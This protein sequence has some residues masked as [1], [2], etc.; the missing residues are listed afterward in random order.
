MLILAL[1]T[2]CDETAVAVIRDGKEILSNLVASQI[3][4][5]KEFG[6]IVPEIAARAHTEKMIPL[7][8]KVVTDCNLSLQNDIDAIAVTF[9]PGLVGS[10]L[11]GLSTA[12]ALAYS[13]NKKLIGV[14]H[15]EA[16]LYAAWLE[17][18]SPP[19][20]PALGLVVSGGHTELV[21]MKDHGKYKLLGATLD[22]AAGEAFDKVAK[23]LGLGYPGGPAIS[24]AARKGNP[25]KFD[26]PRPM[27]EQDNFDFSFAGL[28]TAVLYLIRGDRGKTKNDKGFAQDMAA[29]FQ[30]AVVDTLV[31]K[32]LKAIK[33]YQPKSFILGGG[34]AAN[35]ELRKT[36]KEKLP[37][38]VKFYCP[39]IEL[40]TDNAAIVGANGYF[41]A[42]NKEFISWKD[43]KVDPVAEI[44]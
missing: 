18:N 37:N 43:L 19:K 22:D 21:L 3:D 5:H 36:L 29:S 42:K 39:P 8:K 44:E 20:F 26:L 32:T 14:N 9:G 31:G 40:C 16:H 2:S 38:D 17:E 28:K 15:I 1:E 6:G 13:L 35:L 4:L 23:L 7:L 33:K 12:K 34:V 27:L 10:L 25:D 30:K 11:V 41:K 24:E